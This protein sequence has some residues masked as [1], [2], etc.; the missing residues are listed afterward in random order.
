MK[1]VVR[2]TGKSERMARIWPATS[3]P[4]ISDMVNSVM[5]RSIRVELRRI[6]SMVSGVLWLTVI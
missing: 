1:P 4:F 5:T 3:K 2:M 6:I